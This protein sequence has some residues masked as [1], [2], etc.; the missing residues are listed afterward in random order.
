VWAPPT[1][2]THTNKW[3]QGV[4]FDPLKHQPAAP[5][6]G[7]DKSHPF[8]YQEAQGPL[9][10]RL[11]RWGKMPFLP[12]V[13][14]SVTYT[15]YA[16][17]TFIALQSRLEFREGMQLNAVRNAELVFSRHQFDTAVWIA[18]D[19]KL[20]AVPC[21]DYNDKDKSFK[22]LAK[23]PPDVPCL[24]LAN[25]RKGYGIAYVPLSMKNV[26]KLTGQPADQQAH[27]YIRDYDEHGKGHPNNF[28]YFVRPLVMRGNYEPTKVSA[29]STYE[30]NSAI[31]VF[32]LD[33]DP[34]KKYAEL[35][36]WQ[37]AL[38]NPLRVT[39]E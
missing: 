22:D 39:V 34:T 35:V 13:D 27:F 3:N 9:A 20:H 37:K 38:A 32:S 25:E 12:Q 14:A 5:P 30:E 7:D 17:A 24:G 1:Q 4:A 29:G 33:K 18:N 6:K 21:Y 8:F 23:L 16:G 15:F 19:D 10:Y 31:V 11:T 26:N 2:W 28:H 36:Q